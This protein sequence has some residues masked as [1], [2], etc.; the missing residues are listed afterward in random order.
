MRTGTR[1]CRATVVQMKD[2][3]LLTW[4]RWAAMLWTTLWISGI[5]EGQTTLIKICSTALTVIENLKYQMS[6]CMID[7]ET[8]S[9]KI[10]IRFRALEYLTRACKVL[11]WVQSQARCP[12]LCNP[13]N[14]NLMTT[15]T[16]FRSRLIRIVSVKFLELQGQMLLPVLR[17]SLQVK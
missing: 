3:G 2:L 6:L 8:H 15:F 13:F 10:W 11:I 1:S 5:L 7:Q 14:R 4:C 9:V 12:N 16:L 17:T